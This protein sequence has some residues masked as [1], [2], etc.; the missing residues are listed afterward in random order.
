[1]SVVNS[2]VWPAHSWWDIWNAWLLRMCESNISCFEWLGHL[3]AILNLCVWKRNL[4]MTVTVTGNSETLPVLMEHKERTRTQTEESMDGMEPVWGG[5]C[6]GSTG[7]CLSAGGDE[8]FVASACSVKYHPITTKGP[9]HLK[10]VPWTDGLRAGSLSEQGRGLWSGAAMVMPVNRE[11]RESK[12]WE[13]EWDRESE[14]SCVPAC[15]VRECERKQRLVRLTCRRR[16]S[17]V[18]TT[19]GVSTLF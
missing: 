16:S 11:V 12:R 3:S 2:V 8:L 14:R 19:L 1:M 7:Q 4:S 18:A 13:W 6:H 5:G 17:L 10:E 15:F 9:L